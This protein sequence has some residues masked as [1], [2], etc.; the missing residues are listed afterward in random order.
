[1]TKKKNND[2]SRKMKVITMFQNLYEMNII[3]RY[4]HCIM[5]FF[6]TKPYQK[7][8][9][10]QN[11]SRKKKPKKKQKKKI[12]HTKNVVFDRC[13]RCV[14][15]C[16]LDALFFVF[17]LA[18]SKKA[19]SIYL[20]TVDVHQLSFMRK[21]NQLLTYCGSS[22]ASSRYAQCVHACFFLYRL[23]F[24]VSSFLMVPSLLKWKIIWNIYTNHP[25]Y[26]QTNTPR[27]MYKHFV[28]LLVRLNSW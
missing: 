26:T 20:S 12:P 27:H 6:K 22:S 16:G 21:F 25:S 7:W 2:K 10:L 4:Q 14:A 15:L 23:F 24:R 3:A 19:S 1:M 13:W 28:G 18:D 11:K 9:N 5:T 17:Y 8:N